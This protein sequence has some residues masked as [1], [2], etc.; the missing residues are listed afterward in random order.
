M[1]SV[2]TNF[3]E[4]AE[5]DAPQQDHPVLGAAHRGGHH[6]PR[7]DAGGRDD[8]AGARELEQV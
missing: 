3:E 8:Q 1:P 7:P 2:S 4:R 6:I 5:G